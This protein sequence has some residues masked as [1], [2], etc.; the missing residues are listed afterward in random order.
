MLANSVRLALPM[1]T[2]PAARSL[3]ATVASPLAWASARASE[4]AVVCW[5]S[6]VAML[7]FSR[8]GM[9]CSGSRVRRSGRASIEA[10]SGIASGFTSRTAFSAGPCWS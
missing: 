4:P 10:A 1:I 2:A 3:A 9:P 7:S 8:I 5:L 6:P